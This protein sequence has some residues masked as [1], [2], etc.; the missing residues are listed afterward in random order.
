MDRDTGQTDLQGILARNQSARSLVVFLISDNSI[1]NP[2]VHI[3][4]SYLGSA[5]LPEYIKIFFIIHKVPKI[6]FEN[7]L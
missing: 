7:K 5:S 4:Y 6:K 1:S 3:Q 2:D